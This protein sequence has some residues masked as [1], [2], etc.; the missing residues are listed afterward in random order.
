MENHKFIWRRVFGE[1]FP[2]DQVKIINQHWIYRNQ[3]GKIIGKEKHEGILY[4]RI[5]LSE[6][7]MKLFDPRGRSKEEGVGWLKGHDLIL[8]VKD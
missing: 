6:K 7:V 3:K 8:M 2:G 4:Y 5:K 1:L